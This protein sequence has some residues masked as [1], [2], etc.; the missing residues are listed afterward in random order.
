[1][2]NKER[3]SDHQE[4]ASARESTIVL[5]E[6]LRRAPDD[7][8]AVEELYRR[9]RAVLLASIRG[10][11]SRRLR[12]RLDAEDVLHTAFI[13]AMETLGSFQPSDDRAFF[14]WIHTIA[15]HHVYDV[16]RR[17][18]VGQVRIPGD[19]RVSRLAWL[20]PR[21]RN[22][23]VSSD[24]ARRESIDR[25]LEKVRPKEAEVI[26]S[27]LID[28]MSFESIASRWALSAESARRY[29]SRALSRLK[30]VARRRKGESS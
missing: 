26:R 29:Y 7:D 21:G 16:H 6:R 17:H 14:A 23:S 9:A 30:E 15:R 2:K 10:A 8:A 3:G 13:R 18:S 1:M 28:G 25:M 20:T 4:T 12:S 22:R 19:V 5:V 27:R 11:I 24:L